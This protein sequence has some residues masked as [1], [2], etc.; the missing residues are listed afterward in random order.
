MGS[1]LSNVKQALRTIEEMLQLNGLGKIFHP[2]DYIEL[3]VVSDEGKVVFKKH[4]FASALRKSFPSPDLAKEEYAQ[5]PV[6]ESIIK[7]FKDRIEYSKSDNKGRNF[8]NQK[9]IVF[10]MTNESSLNPRLP[11]GEYDA[12]MNYMFREN[13]GLFNLAIVDTSEEKSPDGEHVKKNPYLLRWVK[14]IRRSQ[15]VALS[16]MKEVIDRERPRNAHI[17]SA[18]QFKRMEDWDV[19]EVVTFLE[20]LKLGKEATEDVVAAFKEGLVDGETL[21]EYKTKEDLA[22]ELRVP[23]NIASRILKKRDD[24]QGQ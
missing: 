21:L 2:S 12:Q 1:Y 16:D 3:R 10:C 20:G 4:N 22:E 9:F 19:D 6:D 11:P 17:L 24:Y 5:F 13:G 23:L 14:N 8:Q 7:I 15:C 18:K